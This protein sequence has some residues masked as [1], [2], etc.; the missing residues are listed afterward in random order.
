MIH[1]AEVVRSVV[2]VLALVTSMMDIP[3]PELLPLGSHLPPQIIFFDDNINM[4]IAVPTSLEAM[5][6]R[7][8]IDT[9]SIGYLSHWTMVDTHGEVD[10][11][12]HVKYFYDRELCWDGQSD[13]FKVIK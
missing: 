6:W 9:V 8:G 3:D 4:G 12:I 5:F 7:K 2:I 13:V 11:V 1:V 10:C